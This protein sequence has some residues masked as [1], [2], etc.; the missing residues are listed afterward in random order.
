MTI[1]KKKNEK[2]EGSKKR[3]ATGDVCARRKGLKQKRREESR[4]GVGGER[5]ARCVKRTKW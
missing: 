3:N 1:K 5:Q 2:R 4:E